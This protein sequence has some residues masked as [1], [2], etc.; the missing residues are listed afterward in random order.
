MH[1][2][3]HQATGFH[4]ARL[5]YFTVDTYQMAVIW[6]YKNTLSL[7]D[8]TASHVCNCLESALLLKFSSFPCG[9]VQV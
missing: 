9:L 3:D 6:E 2:V 5:R 1:P 8:S 7:R 4:P